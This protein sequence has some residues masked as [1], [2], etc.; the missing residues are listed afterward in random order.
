M[1]GLVLGCGGFIGVVALVVAAWFLYDMLQSSNLLASARANREAG[2]YAAA[3]QELQ[4]LQSDYSSFGA[5]DEARALLPQVRLEWANALRDQGAY[6]EALLRYDEVADLALAD[7]IAQGKQQTRLE[8]G[9][10]LLQEGEFAR[11]QEQ[12]DQVLAEAEEGSPI[13]NEARAALPAVYVGLAEEALA[14]GDVTRAFAN[15]STVLRDYQSG[16]GRERALASFRSM[17]EPLYAAAQQQRSSSNYTQAEPMLVAIANY[18]PDDP[19]AAQVESELP[20]FYFEWGNALFAAEQFE[21]A[22]GVYE[23]LLETYPESEFAPQANA[24]LIDAQVVAIRRSEAAGALPAPQASGG[25]GDASTVTYE[26][27]N[28]TE[29]PIV[30]LMSGPQSQA[31]RLAASAIDEVELEAGLYTLVVK[32]DEEAG[33]GPPCQDIIPFTGES[34]FESGTIYRSSFY[35]ETDAE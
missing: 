11:A 16:E 22:V 4:T 26:V 12:F 8:W 13:Y 30:V 2:N 25:S 17:V 14:E 1:R 28:D 27:E 32:T 23:H 35:I 18:A 21:D 3:V 15:L 7:V 9:N 33:L 5:A 31:L 20:A 34:T 29:C 6:A 24:A 10:A 19:L